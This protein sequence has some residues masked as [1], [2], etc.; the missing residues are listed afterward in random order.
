MCNL[1]VGDLQISG[2]LFGIFSPDSSN[3]SCVIVNSNDD[4]ILEREESFTFSLSVD[5]RAITAITPNMGQIDIIDNDSKLL[6]CLRIQG[7]LLFLLQEC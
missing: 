1:C 3:P 6:C 5:D 4:T 2:Q 7:K